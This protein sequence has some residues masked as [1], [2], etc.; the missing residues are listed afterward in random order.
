MP[1][2]PTSSGCRSCR[3]PS[4]SLA[5]A[6]PMPVDAPVMTTDCMIGP[7]VMTRQRA[8]GK[9]PP[10]RLGEAIQMDWIASPLTLLAMTTIAP[11]E[12]KCT[13]ASLLGMAVDDRAEQLP[14]LA[15]EFHHLHLFDRIE[16]R[17]RGLDADSRDISVDLEIEIGNHLHD[18]LAGEFVAAP[19]QHFD[20]CG[21]QIVTR[22]RPALGPVGLR[23]ILRH[24]GAEFL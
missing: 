2:R 12:D 23:I 3:P 18:V 20:Q 21:R 10:D 19:L 15:G 11:Q 17:R 8:G 22:E 6:Q 9:A 16:V 14:V 24:E 7:S 1:N 4:C 13:R 5:V